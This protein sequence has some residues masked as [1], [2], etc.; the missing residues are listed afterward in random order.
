M[1]YTELACVGRATSPRPE[2]HRRHWQELEDTLLLGTDT[3][4]RCCSH[5]G[6]R[7]LLCLPQFLR[8]A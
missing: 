8:C 2:R 3:A 5:P 4:I 7:L 1:H 6:H